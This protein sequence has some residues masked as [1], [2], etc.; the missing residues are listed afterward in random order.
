MKATVCLLILVLGGDFYSTE[1][2]QHHSPTEQTDFSAEAD[3]VEKPVPLPESVLVILR[4]DEVVRALLENEN[5]PVQKLPLSWFSASVIHLSGKPPDLIVMG[6]ESL[7]GANISPFWVFKHTTDGY[8]LVLNAPAHNLTIKDTRWNGHRE[9]ELRSMTAAKISTVL[10]RY[11]GKE[12]VE[13]KS[14]LE[15]IR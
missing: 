5:I 4:N 2:K 11:N 14:R 7:R 1:R 10:C 6:E 9:I 12:Y 13:Y 8:R 15:S 3:G